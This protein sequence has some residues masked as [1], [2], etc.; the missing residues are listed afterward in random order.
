[1]R[2]LGVRCAAPVVLMQQRLFHPLVPPGPTWSDKTLDHLKRL[3]QMKCLLD[4]S[5]TS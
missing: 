3:Q 4:H 2:T 1:M 5:S